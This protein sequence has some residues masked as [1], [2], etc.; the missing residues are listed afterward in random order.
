MTGGH[1]KLAAPVDALDIDRRSPRGPSSGTGTGRDCPEEVHMN[2]TVLQATETPGPTGAPSDELEGDF[3]TGERTGPKA[4]EL[5]LH[6]GD[7]AA[8]ERTTLEVAGGDPE[9]DLHGDFAAG[10]RTEPIAAEDSDEGSFG[11]TTPTA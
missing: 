9:A 6:E 11:D 10:E 1:D 3:A 2:E 7:F 5:E 8:G 4:G